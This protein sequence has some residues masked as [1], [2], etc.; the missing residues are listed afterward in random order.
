M[1]GW[2]G[3]HMTR[4]GVG[5]WSGI[6]YQLETGDPESL[7]AAGRARLEIKTKAEHKIKVRCSEKTGQVRRE[8][9]RGSPGKAASEEEVF[10][11]R[12]PA[13]QRPWGSFPGYSRYTRLKG[14]VTASALPP[15]RSQGRR[16]AP[17]RPQSSPPRGHSS[18]LSQVNT[19]SPGKVMPPSPQ[20]THSTFSPARATCRKP[21]GLF[22]VEPRP[23]SP[24]NSSTSSVR[25]SSALLSSPPVSLP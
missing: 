4:R 13:G 23:G 14:C 1:H 2:P 20:H 22:P 18:G 3:S 21:Q 10:L 24:S 11:H 16:K 9:C 7:S 6:W 25:P 5:C 15:A 19:P 17:T 12:E 8:R